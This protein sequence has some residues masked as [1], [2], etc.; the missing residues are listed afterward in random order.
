MD[1]SN[2]T[3]CWAKEHERLG[4]TEFIYY[5]ARR[6]LKSILLTAIIVDGNNK[7][8]GRTEWYDSANWRSPWTFPMLNFHPAIDIV[9]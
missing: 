8:Q 2:A 9:T 4:R 1:N 3:A 6:L 5:L 7:C